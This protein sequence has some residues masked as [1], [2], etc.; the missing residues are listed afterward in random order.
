MIATRFFSNSPL[1]IKALI[2]G[3]PGSGKGTISSR[4][5]RDFGLI[6]LS[7]GDVL[8]SHIEKESDIGAKAK[9]Y[10]EK[11][12]LVPDDVMVELMINEVSSHLNKGW[13]LDGIYIYI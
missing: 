6:H 4:I 8:R 5:V 12:E 13:L 10:I 2:T 1:L 11:G 3:A 7:S 9:N